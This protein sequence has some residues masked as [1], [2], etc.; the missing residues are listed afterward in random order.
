MARL[1]IPPDVIEKVLNH[2]TGVISGVAA[3]YNRY[4]YV[5]EKRDALERWAEWVTDNFA[6][7]DA[8]STH[9]ASP[10]NIPNWLTPRQA[11]SRCGQELYGSRWK[12][13]CLQE[14]PE[15]PKAAAASKDLYTALCSGE[16]SAFIHRGEDPIK[17]GSEELVHPMFD[18][19][20]ERD[21][22]YIGQTLS[23][24]HCDIHAAE[25]ERFLRGKRPS[26]QGSMAA[27]DAEQNFI[28]VLS[29]KMRNP[30]PISKN[31][32]AQ[33]HTTSSDFQ[34]APSIAAGKKQSK[35]L[36]QK[37]GRVLA[38]QNNLSVCEKNLYAIHDV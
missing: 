25:L 22:V 33:S 5:D 9:A 13:T 29:Q 16:V 15:H 34:L 4:G 36:E 11:A 23:H 18:F 32:G 2:R 1:G 14:S 17:L 7:K 19:D 8:T 35:A 3:V 27:G 38:D 6:F 24:W 28:E 37:V 31:T 12:Q 21:R 26:R 10:G 30:N 20:F